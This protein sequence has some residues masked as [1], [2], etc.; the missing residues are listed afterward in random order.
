MTTTG[1]IV[2][3]VLLLAN[4]VLV[5]VGCRA[6]ALARRDRRRAEH[7]AATASGHRDRAELAIYNHHLRLRS[8]EK[9]HREETQP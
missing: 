1:Y 7:A 3:A 2:A 4:L 8:R 6:A 5:T 9:H